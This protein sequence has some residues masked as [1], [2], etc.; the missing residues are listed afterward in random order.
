V[1]EKKGSPL[2]LA[3]LE[4]GAYKWP[5]LLM[6]SLCLS[7]T[8]YAS[9]QSLVWQQHAQN[10]IERGGYQLETYGYFH[11]GA[12]VQ[13]RV[14]AMEKPQ[15]ALMLSINSDVLGPLNFTKDPQE[16][17]FVANE[18]IELSGSSI[19]GLNIELAVDSG[20]DPLI[21]NWTIGADLPFGDKNSTLLQRRGPIQSVIPVFHAKEN[22]VSLEFNSHYY[23][24]SSSN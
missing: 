24:S 3:W 1:I 10:N 15:Q 20:K 9:Q 23:R 18:S 4:M 13:L 12:T 8:P 2:Y 5:L 7:I 11:P 17:A 16:G 14:L 6:I 21:V 19:Q 22:Q